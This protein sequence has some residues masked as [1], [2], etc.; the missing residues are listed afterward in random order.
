MCSEERILHT[1]CRATP[2]SLSVS[3][4]GVPFEVR[5]KYLPTVLENLRL[6][7]TNCQEL[8]VIFILVEIYTSEGKISVVKLRIS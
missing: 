6:K 2:K 1:Y 5:T 8:V 7:I 3:V 4:V